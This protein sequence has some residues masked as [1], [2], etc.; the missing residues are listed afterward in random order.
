MH[1]HI[2]LSM[3][4]NFIAN[5]FSNLTIKHYFVFSRLFSF[6]FLNMIQFFIALRLLMISITNLFSFLLIFLYWYILDVRFKH[7]SK[8]I[9]YFIALSCWYLLLKC[10]ISHNLHLLNFI[11]RIQKMSL[12]A[13][14]KNIN[15]KFKSNCTKHKM[16]IMSLCSNSKKIW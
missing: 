9:H 13:K 4:I 8:M 2:A 16:S 7:C 3:L 14:K 1:Y 12:I 11:R 5:K 15:R 6:S 10:S